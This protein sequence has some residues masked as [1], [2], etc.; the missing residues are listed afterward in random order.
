MNNTKLLTTLAAG[1]L[2]CGNLAAQET[3][4][5]LSS[6]RSES[7]DVLAVPG[8][9]VDHRGIVINPTPHHL[10]ADRS[11]TLD[12]TQGL[13][14]KDLRGRFADD[15]GFLTPSKKGPVL[16]IDFGPGRLP[17]AASSP[18]REPTPC[19]SGSRGSGSRD[20]TNAAPSTA[21]RRSAS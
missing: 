4:F 12:L 2:L 16:E 18:V 19:R 14:I 9:R 21:S 11:R 3:E 13:R 5:D 7:Q 8:Q 15:L 6:Q 17:N 10:T 1:L 20:T